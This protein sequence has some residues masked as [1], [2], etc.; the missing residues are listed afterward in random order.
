M[1]ITLQLLTFDN[2]WEVGAYSKGELSELVV[3]DIMSFEYVSGGLNHSGISPWGSLY[4]GEVNETTKVS[5]KIVNN[6]GAPFKN[7]RVIFTVN[8]F[9]GV[10][11]DTNYVIFRDTIALD[12]P[13]GKGN[14]AGPVVFRWIP[15]FAGSY[16]FNITIHVPN[17]RYPA[18]DA[19][20][21]WGM[22]YTTANSKTYWNGYWIGTYS[23]DCSSMDGWSTE[24]SGGI[25]GNNWHVSEHP[26]GMGE[27]TLHTSG[28]VFWVGNGSS[29]FGPQSG[30]YSL[31][32]PVFDL[33]RFDD[34]AY[35]LELGKGTPQIYFL[36]RYKGN[37]TS[38]GISGKAGLF[39][40]ISVDEG[41]TWDRLL[42]PLDRHI[43]IGGNTT[44]PIW[45]Y[46]RHNTVL[47]SE[48][49]GIDLSKYQGKR[50]MLKLEYRPS[51]YSETGY[52]LDDFILIGKERVDIS[53][54]NVFYHTNETLPARIGTPVDYQI[55][56]TTISRAG[57]VM[58]RAEVIAASRGIDRGED[59]NIDPWMVALDHDISPSA[60][61]NVRFYP[62]GSLKA[63]PGWIKVRLMAENTIRD[64]VLN[65]MMLP[66]NDLNVELSG[67]M[68]GPIT[69]NLLPHLYLYLN[70]SGNTDE[71]I[72][73]DF[74]S[75][76]GLR[77]N[78]SGPVHHLLRP[79][80]RKTM[81]IRIDP[82]SD[83][84][85]GPRHGFL[86]MYRQKTE[87]TGDR[88]PGTIR[89]GRT[90]PDWKVWRLDYDYI[91][92]YNISLIASTRYA[93]IR[94]PQRQGSENITFY[95]GLI[96][97]GNGNDRVRLNSE[98]TIHS[99]NISI[100]HPEYVDVRAMSMDTV[101]PINVMIS[102]PISPG[103][104]RFR[105]NAISQGEE[106][107]KDNYIDLSI[108]I[109]REEIPNGVYIM[110]S[111]LTIEPAK[112]IVGSESV[113][114]FEAISFGMPENTPFNVFL[115]KNGTI[116]S[117]TQFYTTRGSSILCQISWIPLSSGQMILTLD[118]EGSIHRADIRLDLVQRINVSLRVY[119]ID[120]AVDWHSFPIDGNN[121]INETV[122]PGTYFIEITLKNK[123]DVMAE[124]VTI[125]TNV[126]SDAGV[127][128][129]TRMNVTRVE[130]GETIVVGIG[131][132]DLAPMRRYSFDVNVPTIG[133]W[134]D[135]EPNDNHIIGSINVGK[136][137]PDEP[138]WREQLF[139]MASL[140]AL[141]LL[142]IFIIVM[143]YR[144]K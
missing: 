118:I 53:K 15:Q 42:D 102:Y 95:L 89:E 127:S 81:E 120:L 119:H 3:L 34:S 8:W 2:D 135:M 84:T 38:E 114:S 100:D 97:N 39:H 133:R 13:A 12:V 71:D 23:H 92:T 98:M 88:I 21:A 36:Y 44:S 140:G 1:I 94:D 37:V 143:M 56:I 139:L 110:N 55:D 9:D 19:R 82:G 65:F 5:F 57:P 40:Y 62:K 103:L 64:V 99:A 26:L 109:G 107:Q 51:G 73:I 31:I 87:V 49:W 66:I 59:V 134:L 50:I 105:L 90:P 7:V 46:P 75:D 68:E 112:A 137:P 86:I 63:G 115:R 45:D 136:S 122:Y 83:D 123:G 117:S 14:K 48:R 18:S 10:K 52:F 108:R 101:V 130:A 74:G 91:Q 25:E 113:I 77:W 85:A 128:I 16:M 61:M 24:V 54:F 70:N 129:N 35:N 27:H 78:W 138:I 124:F 111:T 72:N 58:V 30:V 4:F 126:T 41:L 28:M 32:S 104:Y 93:L 29:F 6:D 121:E 47:M 125:N 43:V 141:L 17:D 116:L 96:N 60:T 131:P 144:R 22:N 142:F 80:D 20:Y 67:R 33:T 11:S 79:G 69:Y 106:D 76:Q 132:F